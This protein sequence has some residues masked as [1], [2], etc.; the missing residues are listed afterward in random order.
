MSYYTVYIMFYNILDSV[1]YSGLK[2]FV[3]EPWAS[4]KVDGEPIYVIWTYCIR[5]IFD[6]VWIMF[7]TLDIPFC[8]IE[9]VVLLLLGSKSCKL[10]TKTFSRSPTFM[11]AFPNNMQQQDSSNDLFSSISGGRGHERHFLRLA[12]DVAVTLPCGVHGLALRRSLPGLLGR[13]P[14]EGSRSGHL[15]HPHD[16]VQSRRSHRSGGRQEDHLWKTSLDNW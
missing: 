12:Q 7:Y 10:Q 1:E 14:G 4:N 13:L 6:L 9:K 15:H 5:Y 11:V 3:I 8:T 2:G 16:R